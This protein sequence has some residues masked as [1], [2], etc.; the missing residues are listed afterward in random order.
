MYPSIPSSSS[1]AGPPAGQSLGAAYY[2]TIG[3]GSRPAWPHP[4]RPPPPPLHNG[5]VSEP[6][7]PSES[8]PV[9]SV[10]M[11][12]PFRTGPPVRRVL[13]R[14]LLAKS[15]VFIIKF[16]WGTCSCFVLVLKM[17]GMTGDDRRQFGR[18]PQEPL[19]L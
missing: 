1:S 19:R 16:R 10:Q 6:D 7:Q 14:K 2:P 11:A 17:C 9:V 13:I 12:E 8:H 4:S 3:Q 5:P 15:A 18:H